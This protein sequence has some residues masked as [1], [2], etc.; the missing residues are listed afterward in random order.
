MVVLSLYDEC[1]L[2]NLIVNI[3]SRKIFTSHHCSSFS[4]TTNFKL[5]THNTYRTLP[6]VKQEHI[7]TVAVDTC[8][9]ESRKSRHAGAAGAACLILNGEDQQDS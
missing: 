5:Q 9:S 1:L 4:F 3:H 8:L 2:F 7:S 6:Y